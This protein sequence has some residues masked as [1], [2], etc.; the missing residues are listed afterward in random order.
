MKN[1]DEIIENI[2]ESFDVNRIKINGQ[3]Y[4]EYLE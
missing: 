4:W 1:I 3:N 2:E